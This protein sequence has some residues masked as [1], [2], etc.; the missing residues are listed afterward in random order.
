MQLEPQTRQFLN[1]CVA[2]A[3]A[4]ERQRLTAEAEALRAEIAAERDAMY[5]KLAE[6]KASIIGEYV[7]M[8]EQL[9][10]T[11]AELTKL[12]MLNAKAQ[13]EREALWRDRMWAD[14]ILA[15]RDGAWLN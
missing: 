10:A 5:A 15:Q 11:Q 8:R 13:Q 7:E 9:A 4:H 3:R 6:L 12:R 14:A 1:L 2:R